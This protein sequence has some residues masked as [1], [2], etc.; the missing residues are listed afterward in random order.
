MI[1]DF[2]KDNPLLIVAVF[3][4]VIEVIVLV[5]SFRK[6]KINQDDFIDSILSDK[7]PSFI[8]LAE[9]TCAD[10]SSK[11]CLVVKLAIESI[12]KYIKKDD[13]PFYRQLIIDKVE[14][15]L[16]TPQKKEN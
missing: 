12:R 2:I 13:E 4:L 14:S 9:S 10:G 7:L 5:R 6:G 15:I 3:S 16:S 11:L 1:L 8:N